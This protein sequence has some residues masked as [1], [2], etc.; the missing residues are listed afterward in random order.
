MRIAYIILHYMAGK[1]TIECAESILKATEKSEHESLIIIVDNGSLNDS[2]QQICTFFA[3]IGKIITIH[4]DENLGFAK[5]NNL[6]FCYAK[7]NWKADFIVQLN[8]DTIVSQADFNEMIV[9]KY[10]ER[11]YA[12]LGPD[13]ITADGYHQNPVPKKL[14]NH[15][16]L[17]IY[18]LK[19]YI[20]I[21]CLYLNIE[22][23]IR[24]KINLQQK[25]YRKIA[26]NGDIENAFLHGSCFVFSQ[27]YIRVFDGMD[28][29]TFL[30]W[31]EDILKLKIDKF[32]LNSVYSGELSIF[33]KE[34]IATGMIHKSH[35]RKDIW[36]ERQLIKS[37]RIYEQVLTEIE[38]KEKKYYENR[39]DTEKDN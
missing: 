4:S 28:A 22:K 2:Y 36:V 34:D 24:N 10:K 3:D 38:K 6:G 23:N 21:F 13:I 7:Y 20:K 37:S 31:E 1:D 15:R 27:D 29:R 25:I 39:M 30:Y 8:N 18:R 26:Q 14:F 32:K 9:K 12:V 19:K 16:E 17:K 33:H 5:G 35:K 11:P